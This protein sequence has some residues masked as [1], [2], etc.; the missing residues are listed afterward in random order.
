MVDVKLNRIIERVKRDTHAAFGE[1]ISIKTLCDVLGFNTSDA[2]KR[3]IR[4]D[5]DLTIHSIPHGGERYIQTDELLELLVYQHR[6]AMAAKIN[7][8]KSGGVYVEIIDR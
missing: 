3:A 7:H 1:R 5:L 4:D 8:V 6:K 2:L